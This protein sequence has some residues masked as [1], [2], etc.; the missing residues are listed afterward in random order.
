MSVGRVGQCLSGGW[1]SVCQ[2]GGALSVRRVGQCLSGGWGTVC[3]E[4]GALSVGRVW[5]PCLCMAGQE[6]GLYVGL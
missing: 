3:Q 6:L 1:G 2:E 4:G 5:H